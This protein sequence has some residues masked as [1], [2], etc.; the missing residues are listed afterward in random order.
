[1]SESK[2]QSMNLLLVK[3]AIDVQNR[4]EGLM[5]KTSMFPSASC[6]DHDLERIPQRDPYPWFESC[7]SASQRVALSI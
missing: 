7:K 3:T 2:R 4:R 1:M 5:H 6:Q